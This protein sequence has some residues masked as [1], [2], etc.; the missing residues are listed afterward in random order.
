MP[1]P[2]RVVLKTYLTP[3]EYKQVEE[4]AEQSGLT[5]SAFARQVCLNN[6]ISTKIDNERIVE[7][8]KSSADLGRLGG[9]LKLGLSKGQLDRRKGN[10]L[11]AQ[12]LTLKEKFEKQIDS[13][14]GDY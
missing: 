5:L 4:S 9:L 11:L 3:E 8:L 10:D 2:N 7:L 12:I 1:S 14:L 13:F 6:K